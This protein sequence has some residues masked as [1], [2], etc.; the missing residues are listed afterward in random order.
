MPVPVNPV[1]I[2]DMLGICA[3]ALAGYIA[4]VRRQ[5]DILG[6][7]VAAF[8][9]AL[10]GGIIRDTLVD[11]T[12]FAFREFYPFV[13][14]LGVCA[15]ARALRLGTRPG[16]DQHLLFV[17]SDSLGLVAFALTGGMIAL[18]ND[19]NLLGVLS[20]A[21]ITAVGGGM[22][23]DAL[24]NEVPF[25]LRSDFYAS[26]ALLIGLALWLIDAIGQVDQ[27]AVASLGVLAYAVRIWAWKTGWRLPGAR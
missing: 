2:A 13:C 5:L 21:F 20:L 3:F 19:L 17:L 6:A 26:V 4:G 15:L 18:Q 23:R 10:G 22:V 14:V 12:P 8:C 24:L 25:V 7:L 16:V 9:T 27:Y 1:V 11:A